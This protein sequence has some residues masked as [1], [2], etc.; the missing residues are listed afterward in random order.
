MGFLTRYRQI[1]REGKCERVTGGE[2]M[3]KTEINQYF[4]DEF[5]TVIIKLISKSIR[6]K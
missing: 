3:Y 2:S 5:I 1:E 4:L 6:V